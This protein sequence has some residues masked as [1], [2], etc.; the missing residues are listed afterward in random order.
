MIQSKTKKIGVFTSGGDAPGMNAAV[1]AVVRTATY[2][3]IETAAIYRGYEGMIENDIEPISARTVSNILHR[4]GT[5]LKSARSKGFLTAEGRETAFKNLQSNGID[6]LVAIGGDGT[7]AGAHVFFKEHGVRTVG[8]PGTIDN[9]LHGTDN[10]L[11]FDTAN[12]TVIEAVDKIRDTARSHNRLFFV[13]VMGRDSGFIAAHTGVASGALEII[14]PEVETTVD[15][16]IGVLEEAKLHNKTSSIV[17]VS[18]GGKTGGAAALAEKVKKQFPHYDTKVTILG[19]I[20][21]GGSP[22][23]SDRILASKLGVASVE[24][25]HRGDGDCMVGLVNN[26]LVYTPFAAAITDKL[27]IDPELLRIAKILST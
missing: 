7:F 2:Y 4:G 19:H 9:D 16:L 14:I 5:I 3:G 11:G 25:L 27:P 17:M 1:R 13:E 15:D 12:N 24:A 8:I 18:E 10:T 20:Q 26:K 22:S 23:A 6:A 21:R